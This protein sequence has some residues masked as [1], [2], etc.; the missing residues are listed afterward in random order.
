MTLWQDFLTNNQRIIHKWTSY[1]PVYE[2]HFA[3]YVDRPVLV[4]E[5]GVYQGGSLQ[6]WKRYFGPRARIVGIDINP[7]CKRV[8]EDQIFVRIG[9][10]SDPVFLQSVLDEFGQPDIVIDDGSHRQDH[11]NA[12]F[13]YLYPAMKPDGIYVVEDLHTAYSPA[14]LGGLKHPGSFIETA[15]NLVDD[16]NAGFGHGTLEPNDFSL[17]TL[18]MHMYPSIIVF[19]RGVALPHHD[20]K[21]GRV[22]VEGRIPGRS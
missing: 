9:D 6:M 22:P 14:F 1:F 7:E 3:R 5:I 16:L 15:K 4:L 10:Q 21:T 17:S 2:R 19:E 8:E 12:S 11:V 13:M 18:S 20:V